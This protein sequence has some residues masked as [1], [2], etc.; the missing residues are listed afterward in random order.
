MSMSFDAEEVPAV[1]P[2]PEVQRGPRD[3]AAAEGPAPEVQRDPEGP[4]PE[5]QRGELL[6]VAGT[7]DDVGAAE[8]SCKARVGPCNPCP[9][10]RPIRHAW[11][12]VK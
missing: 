8:D 2:A 7:P 12:C 6:E 10:L 1:G 9:T 4:A 11:V 5:V 3:P